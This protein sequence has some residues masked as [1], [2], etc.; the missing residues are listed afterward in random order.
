MALEE[1]L[2]DRRYC[3]DSRHTLIRKNVNMATRNFDNRVKEF[4]KHI[5]MSKENPMNV[6]LFN[7]RVEFQARGAAHIHGVLWL[8]FEKTF[9]Q[10]LD[11]QV[12]KSVFQKFK[13][14]ENLEEAEEQEVIKFIDTFVTCT[15]DKEE[16]KKLLIRECG[17][18]DAVAA[19]AVEIARTVNKHRHNKSCR[20]YN[21]KCRFNY[22][23][24]PSVRTL[25]TKNPEVY[26]KEELLKCDSIEEEV[27]WLNK[28]MATN[29]KILDKVKEILE[30]Y[31]EMD[32][33][34]A[35]VVELKQKSTRE[36]I[37][38]ILMHPDIQ[39]HVGPNEDILERYQ[40]ALVTSGV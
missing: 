16:A 18:K 22:P 12:L 28:K 4:M 9:P 38:N 15:L 25:L 14:D 6:K 34:D 8:D 33:E 21:T 31:D 23:K 5:V 20:K 7:Y 30:S 1:Y 17:D 29:K 26:Y 32:P 24:F 37:I 11:G 35:R 13:N 39:K 19:K 27:S 36:A 2:T 3:D 40:E 10:N